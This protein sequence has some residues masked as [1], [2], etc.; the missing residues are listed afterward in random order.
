MNSENR[1]TTDNTTF[2][3]GHEVTQIQAKRAGRQIPKIIRYGLPILTGVLVL[4]V[5]VM[6]L[7]LPQ[8]NRSANFDKKQKALKD[9]EQITKNAQ[10]L[11]A[12]AKKSTSTTKRTGAT[13]LK[14]KADVIRQQKAELERKTTETT[15]AA[16][17][18]PITEETTVETKA[19]QPTE[20]VTEAPSTEE[21]AT[22]TETE[23]D[24][25]TVEA[26]IIEKVETGVEKY[27]QTDL[28]LRDGYTFQ[29]QVLS[30]YKPASKV[31]ETFIVKVRGSNDV[32]EDWSYVVDE[33]GKEGYVY[34]A[35]L[36][37]S[38]PE[39]VEEK[40]PEQDNVATEFTEVSGT[41][42]VS[43]SDGAYMRTGSSV[44]SSGIQ[45]LYYGQAVELLGKGTNDQGEVWYQIS[46]DGTVGY[47]RSDLLQDEEINLA[48]E[49]APDKDDADNTEVVTPVESGESS[50]TGNS[51]AAMGLEFIGTEYIYGGASPSGFD[52]SGL[53]Y[54]LYKSHGISIPRTADAQATVGSSVPFSPGDYSQLA[55]GDIVT[56]A[57]AGRG[58]HHSGIYIGDNSFVHA[59]DYGVGV[60]VSRLDSSYYLYRLYSVRRV[61]Y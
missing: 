25:N 24:N 29:N 39:V 6:G 7:L 13:L 11:S 46:K 38:A 45:V 55:P 5:V 4:S 9:T 18:E 50:A 16:T 57:E 28:N 48:E 22:Q 36:G 12:S 40:T 31:T 43:A 58:V 15:P 56:F 30:V 8:I 20:P 41:M 35:Y 17:T 3:D 49:V 47:M 59:S 27:A 60:I 19:P 26:E 2:L 51:I 21:S 14:V 54:Y 34:T 52:C 61:V 53:V 1:R 32:V 10:K 33:E 44:S 37:E 23:E 42:Y